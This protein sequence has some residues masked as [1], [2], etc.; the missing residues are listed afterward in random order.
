MAASGYLLQ[1]IPNTRQPQFGWPR[2]KVSGVIG[3]HTAENATSFEGV[4]PGA[5]SVLNFL[6][7]RADHGSYHVLADFDSILPL[8]HPS[9]SVWADTTNNAHAMSVSGALQAARWRELSQGRADQIVVNMAVGA[10]RLVQTAVRDGLLSTPTPARR[11]S[12]QEAISGSRAGFYGHGETNPGTR[13]DPGAHFNWGLFLAQY[14]RAISG[15]GFIPVGEVKRPLLIP[16]TTE[17]GPGIPD[18]FADE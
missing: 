15:G 5:E 10:A 12:A 11:I 4:D 9:W 6:R 18:L 7:T 16:D 17:Y 14:E 8:V 1:D 3:V 2:G 13:Y